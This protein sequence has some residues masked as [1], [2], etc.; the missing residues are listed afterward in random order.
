MHF[1]SILPVFVASSFV[2]LAFNNIFII[3]IC[4]FVFLLF[5]D[6]SFFYGSNHYDLSIRI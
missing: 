4:S 1:K 3:S 5:N 6:I 2:Y